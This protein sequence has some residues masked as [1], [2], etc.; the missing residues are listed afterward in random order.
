ML[1]EKESRSAHRGR[2]M[3]KVRDCFRTISKG[4]DLVS[5]EASVEEVI[6]SVTQDPASRAV[7]VVDA[8]RRLL[9][10]VS[11]REILAVLGSQYVSERGFGQT[12]E[13]LATRAADLMGAPYWGCPSGSR[14]GCLLGWLSKTLS[15]TR[16]CARPMSPTSEL[17]P[18]SLSMPKA[19]CRRS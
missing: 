3:I 16:P 17:G 6:A 2:T 19:W 11:V 10:I 5:P 18:S 15:G 1:T 12:R 4:V 14:A 7:F 13:L 8:K 9:G